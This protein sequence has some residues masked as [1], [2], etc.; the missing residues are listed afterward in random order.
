[1]GPISIRN[2]TTLGSHVT[3]VLLISYGT[4]PI[5]G[6][7]TLIRTFTRY[8]YTRYMIFTHGKMGDPTDSTD[9]TRRNKCRSC[10]SYRSHTANMY[11]SCISYRSRPGKTCM[12][13]LDHTDP[14]QANTCDI[15]FKRSYR[16]HEVNVILI[17]K[18]VQITLDKHVQ[19]MQIIQI[20]PRQT[21]MKD[22]DGTDPTQAD[23]CVRSTV[24]EHTYATQAN[25]CIRARSYRCHPAN[26]I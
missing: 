14:T 24:L 12:K 16:S 1:M 22:L 21:C 20:P 2:E 4:V 9:S 6:T 17:P 3:N 25:A 15:S 11:R 18:I 19:I 8:W 5:Y 10:R 26:T 23:R 7:G 13:N